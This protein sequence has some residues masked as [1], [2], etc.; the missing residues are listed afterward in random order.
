MREADGKHVGA[1]DVLGL[2]LH[3]NGEWF[4]FFDPGS[5]EYLPDSEERKRA[6]EAAEARVVELEAELRTLRGH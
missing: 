2:E 3:A 1:S 4:R 5:G 6:Q